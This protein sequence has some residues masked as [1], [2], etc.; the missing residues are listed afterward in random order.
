M[1]PLKFWIYGTAL[2]AAVSVTLAVAFSNLIVNVYGVTL[3]IVSTDANEFD[4]A[5]DEGQRAA[6]A[7]GAGSSVDDTDDT[8][9]ESTPQ[10]DG[11]N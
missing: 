6:N 5:F 1:A 9:D 4:D 10:G 7:G 11:G 3:G 8:P 2:L